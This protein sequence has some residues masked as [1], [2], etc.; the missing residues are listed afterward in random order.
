MRK[1]TPLLF[2]LQFFIFQLCFSSIAAASPLKPEELF[3]EQSFSSPK[4]SPD[5]KRLLVY[6]QNSV[7]G[8][9][10]I[11]DTKTFAIVG[12]LQ[13]RQDQFAGAFNWVNNDRILYETRERRTGSRQIFGTGQIFSVNYDGSRATMLYGYSAGEPENT[14]KTRIKRKKR[15]KNAFGHIEHWLPEDDEHVLISETP[16]QTKNRTNNL[17][18]RNSS[19]QKLNVYSG[20]TSRV[21]RTVPLKSSNFYFDEKGNVTFAVGINE[22]IETLVYRYNDGE[23]DLFKKIANGN[24][25]M[26]LQSSSSS[27]KL[28]VLSNL[29]GEADKIGLYRMDVKTQTQ[30]LVYEHD[31]VDLSAALY[32]PSEELVAVELH[33]GYPSYVIIPGKSKDK[34]I[35][36]QIAKD[37]RGNSVRI[38][39]RTLAGDKAIIKVSMDTLPDLYYLLDVTSGEKSLLFSRLSI[40]TKRLTYVT[41][42]NYKSFDG[43]QIDGYLTTRTPKKATPT[44]VLV[45][46]GPT[47]RD[48][49]EFN[50]LV[51]LLA[52]HGFA[53]LQVNFRGSSGYGTEHE[54]A[55]NK[56]WGDAI[57]NDILAGLDWAIE[58]GHADKS[59]ACIMGTSFGAYSAILSAELKPDAFKCVV[60]N[61]GIY[62]LPLLYNEGD[63]QSYFLGEYNLNIM[64]GKDTEQLRNFSPVH[65]VK[66]ITAPVFLAHGKQDARAPFEHAELMLEALEGADKKVTTYFKNGETHGFQSNEN[67]VAYLNKVLAFLKQH[68]D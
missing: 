24:I 59:N 14:G 35:F 48:Y 51:Q 63:I 12:A 30:K 62:D 39:S 18:L 20:K 1:I 9:L 40:P 31:R 58:N 5:G 38:I 19:I 55:G 44:I 65:H 17:I 27:K 50:P 25:F 32:G 49:F 52:S 26:P 46:G 2:I 4:L 22:D 36:K 7:A 47:S 16:F 67:Q 11:Y 43:R 56:H 34:K 29:N 21:A 15:G 54:I 57:Q 66:S 53:V 41:P 33:D 6:L 13:L 45:H 23:W 3:P 37:F 28:Y 60:A 10:V 42:I 61:A 68:L 64:I 8:R